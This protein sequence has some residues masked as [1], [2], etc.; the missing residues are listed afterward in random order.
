MI[1][2]AYICY[3]MPLQ[4]CGTRVRWRHLPLKASH[5][6]IMAWIARHLYIALDSSVCQMNKCKCNQV[7]ETLN[8]LLYCSCWYCLFLF[9]H[10][11]RFLVPCCHTRTPSALMSANFSFY[12]SSWKC[13]R[14]SASF[15]WIY[16]EI[17]YLQILKA[18]TELSKCHPRFWQLSNL[19]AQQ[20]GHKR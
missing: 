19:L 20:L 18:S 17:C 16:V 15:Y 10:L 14:L 13:C 11:P 5:R 1:G 2:Y 8:Q 4:C 3:L 6:S 9:I 7:T 12:C